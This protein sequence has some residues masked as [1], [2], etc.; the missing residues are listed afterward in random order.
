MS[1]I[2]F[3]SQNRLFRY[4]KSLQHCKTSRKFQ[5]G[6][7]TLLILHPSAILP[8]S[9]RY[10]SVSEGLFFSYVFTYTL[11]VTGVLN[12]W[13]KLCHYRLLYR[14]LQ[15]HNDTIINR[16]R[17]TSLTKYL[18]LTLFQGFEKGYSR[19]ACG[20]RTETSI[21]W[22]PLLWPST[23]CLSRFPDAQP[24]V[25]MSTLLGAGFL[26]CILS[27]SSLDPNSSAER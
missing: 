27:V 22:S 1:L 24:E 12:L 10:L 25:L 11:S 14:H 6:V 16:R 9:N 2:I 3:S 15:H 19:F 18:P 7:E 26:Y 20:D 13:Q 4:V 21:F 8:L 23:L 5:A 17:K